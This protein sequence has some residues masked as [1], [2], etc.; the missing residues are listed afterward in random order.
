MEYLF[1]FVLGLIWLIFATIHDFKTKEI[2]NWLNFSLIAFALSYRAFYSAFNNDWTF[3]V[4]GLIALGIFVGISFIFYYSRAFAGG[5]A[6]LLMGIGV[7]LPLGNFGSYFWAVIFLFLLFGIG[8][9]YSFL[10]TLILV[11]RKKGFVYEFKKFFK[12][13]E[14]FIY[15]LSGLGF[16]AGLILFIL[17]EIYLSISFFIFG[18][19]PWIYIYSQ[20][21]DRAY[22][23]KLVAPGKLTEGDWLFKDVKVGKQIIKKKVDGLSKE[24]T[25]VLKKF[26]KKVWIREGIPFSISF[27]LAFM[28]FVFLFFL[29]PDFSFLRF[30]SLS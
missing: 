10:Y 30:F 26:G 18:F 4:Y 11:F 23:V 1:L 7:I 20:V 15:G 6:K 13:K 2:P 14:I 29:F 3:F 17:N 25:V 28:V 12:G 24:E 27:L 9:V 21:I 22:M 8:A 16:L 19:I 5:D